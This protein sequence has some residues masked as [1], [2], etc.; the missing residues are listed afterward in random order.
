MAPGNALIDGRYRLMQLVGVGGMA[1]VHRARDERSDREVAVKLMAEH[2]AGDELA[3][4]RFRREGQ[5]ALRMRHP[6][7]VAGLGAGRDTESGRDYIAMEIIDGLN[8]RDRLRSRS[9]V[10]PAEAIAIV[11]QICDALTHAHSQ[12]VVHG[13]VS[14]ANVLI[15]SSDHTAKLADFGAARAIGA[16]S[17]RIAPGQAMGTPG[18]VA[19]E[20]ALGADATPQSDLYSLGAVAFR[21]LAT[22]GWSRVPDVFPTAPLTEPSVTLPALADV[23]RDVPPMVAR[24][25]D[26][27]LASDPDERQGSLAAF[28]AELLDASAPALL[29]A[30]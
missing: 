7:V 30:A 4:R 13:D 27:A 8:A 24:A 28:R 29:R 21:L 2:L 1:T 19:P 25:V 14:P 16:T 3:V 23:G 20:V 15:R 12:G 11:T 10:R 17:R 18:Y 22:K 6:N 9:P 26:T 5:L